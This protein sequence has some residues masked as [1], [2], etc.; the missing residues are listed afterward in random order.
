MQDRRHDLHPPPAGFTVRTGATLS[1]QDV[2]EGKTDVDDRPTDR[3]RF[4]VHFDRLD[5]ERRDLSGALWK[6]AMSSL[7][8]YATNDCLTTM[9][10]AVAWWVQHAEP[11]RE[12][13]R[14]LD[15][16]AQAAGLYVLSRRIAACV[17]S[18]Q[19]GS[20]R[21]LLG[22]RTAHVHRVL[23][24]F[25]LPRKRLG[26]HRGVKHDDVAGRA[27][28]FVGPLGGFNWSMAAPQGS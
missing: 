14:R 15:R 25:S 17:N 12:F 20:I 2:I 11:S 21:G 19:P 7:I 8:N 23:L 3:R 9:Y 22:S 6:P 13:F 16:S 18:R 28:R 1:T 27:D 26:H 4:P 5:V 10:R 24:E